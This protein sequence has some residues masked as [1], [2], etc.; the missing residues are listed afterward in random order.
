M[1]TKNELTPDELRCVCDPAV[2]EFKDTSE[3]EPLDEVIGQKRAEQAIRFGLAM[4]SPGYNIFVT[5]QE[6]TGKTTIVKDIV[7]QLAETLATPAGT[8]FGAV[9][10]KLKTCMEQALRLKKQMEGIY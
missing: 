8:V 2:F 6:G 1:A 9:Q 5:G 7:Q 10:Q 3:I 4:K